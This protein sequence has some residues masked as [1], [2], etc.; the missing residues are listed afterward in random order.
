MI[1][2][3]WDDILKDIYQKEYYNKIKE[4]VRY[5]YNHKTIFPPANKVFYA[6]RMTPYK[7]VKVV[8]LGQDPY[9]GVGEA[10]GLC[11]SVNHGIKMPPSLNNIYKELYSDLGIT[12]T[13]TDLTDWA[14]QGVLL[15]NSVLTV[16]KDKPASHK[17]VGWEE[18]TDEIIMKLNDHDTPIVFIL[19]GNFAKSK[20]KYITNPKH[21]IISSSHPSPFSVNYGFFG[22]KPFSKTNEFLRKNNLEEIKW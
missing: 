3:D 6:L 22:S 5:E 14:S 18:F 8:I 2:N 1:G 7:S 21:L 17:F 12:R 9:H 15:L 16:E 20:I 19:W 4:K 11:F 10:N 13:D